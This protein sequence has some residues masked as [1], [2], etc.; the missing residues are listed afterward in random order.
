MARTGVLGAAIDDDRGSTT[1]RADL[2]AEPVDDSTARRAGADRH[3]ATGRA[4]TA[5]LGLA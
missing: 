3:A 1:D 2:G 4:R 5:P